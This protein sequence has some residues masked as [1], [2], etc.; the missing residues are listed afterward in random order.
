MI[1]KPH[2]K[3]VH[4]GHL[5]HPVTA[6]D[7]NG[8]DV[9]VEFQVQYCSRL[10]KNKICILVN[11]THRSLN[12]PE[13][14]SADIKCVQIEES[15][16]YSNCDRHLADRG[17]QDI[18]V[19]FTTQKDLDSRLPHDKIVWIPYGSIWVPDIEDYP[20]DKSKF[21]L[22]FLPG[23]KNMSCFP[24]HQVR[25]DISD[26]FVNSQ[27]SLFNSLNIHPSLNIKHI[28]RTNHIKKKDPIFDGFQFSIVVENSRDP[29]WFTEKLND[30]LITKTIP[31]YYGAPDIGKYFDAN[32]ILEFSNMG[33]L[34]QVLSTLTPTMY[35]EKLGAVNKN[36]EV[37]LQKYTNMKKQ[38]GKYLSENYE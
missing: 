38:I 29:G 17:V 7:I 8:D 9:G 2:V 10:H 31:I 16:R 15:I 23:A 26:L 5:L 14:L 35:K 28:L 18:D 1:D 6:L 4:L 36:R 21:A 24:G 34:K 12:S 3:R 33:E 27:K 13:F 30:A 37:L 32:G 25:H 19:I 20:Y 22:S 11:P